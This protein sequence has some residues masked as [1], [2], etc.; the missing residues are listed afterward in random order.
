[1]SGEAETEVKPAREQVDHLLARIR[2][3][4]AAGEVLVTS[5]INRVAESSGS[6]S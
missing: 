4:V 5:L 6:A 1:M 2:E 3:R